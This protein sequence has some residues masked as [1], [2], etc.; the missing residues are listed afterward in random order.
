MPPRLVSSI[1]H[2]ALLLTWPESQVADTTPDILCVRLIQ[3]TV[4]NLQTACS[5][6]R[7]RFSMTANMCLFYMTVD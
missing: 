3:M 4:D 7:N 6:S 1:L 2:K 5:K